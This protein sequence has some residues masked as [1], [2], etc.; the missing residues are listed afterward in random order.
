MNDMSLG[1]LSADPAAIIAEFNRRTPGSKRI[2]TDNRKVLADKSSIG[3]G[4]SPALKEAFYSIV[5]ERAEG[6][7]LWDVDGNRYVDILMGLGTN[8]FGHNPAFIRDAIAE[9]LAKG[10]PIGPQSALSGETAALYC[11]LTGMDRVTFSNTGTEAVMT[12]IRIARAATARNRIVVF[13]GSYHG[14][15]DPVLTKAPR[16]EYLR[17]G[18]IARTTGGR[19]AALHPLLK[20]LQFTRAVPGF[21]GIPKAVAR[22]VTMLDYGNPRSL[23]ILRARG[24]RIA[25][26]LVEP[27][28]SRCPELQPLGFLRSL[29]EITARTGTALIFDEMIT[30]FRIHPGGAQA[31]FGVAADIA[32]YSKIAGGGL[33]LSIVAGRGRFMDHIDGG[34]WAFGDDSA[35]QTPTT[36]FAGTF[37]RHPLA[38]AA[39]L[40][41]AKHL[42][43]AGPALQ[44]GLTARTAALVA[45]LND[46]MQ[47]ARLPVVFTSFGSFFSIALTQ[48]AISQAA[49]D[50][51]SI[52]LLTQG[53]HL[54]GGDRGGFL[55]TA[56][57][58]ADIDHIYE[59]FAAG[60]DTL[61]S[62]GLLAP[63]DRSI[64]P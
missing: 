53:V 8:L 6:A 30:G 62:L 56:H 16:L 39:A 37:C 59:A 34:S 24:S 38:L 12:A 21:A 20:R 64:R 2:A 26:V 61:A 10:F 9:R 57:S 33:P 11:K 47:I 14:H 40:A 25:A 17:R 32:T 58:D 52:M 44:E 31:H 63:M 50:L 28:Q 7:Y 29:R 15:A 18:A 43:E 13:T 4:F 54:R 48:S 46:R 23:D 35:P 3:M 41:T 1:P 51:L 60:L 5:A 55:S 45:R 19:F 36:F 22:H 42:I 27:V 49:I